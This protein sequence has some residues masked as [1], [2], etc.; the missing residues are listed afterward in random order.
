MTMI[1]RDRIAGIVQARYNDEH[2][3]IQPVQFLAA[4]H[5]YGDKI[6]QVISSIVSSWRLTRSA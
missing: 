4:V 1:A 3:S 2:R 5:Q 6:W